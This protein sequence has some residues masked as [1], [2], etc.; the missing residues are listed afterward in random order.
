M[1]KKKI[2]VWS[3]FNV[4][5]GFSNVS[6]ALMEEMH[7]YYDVSVL[8]INYFGDTKY[9]TSK[10]FV[11]SVGREDILG[12]KRMNKVIEAVEPDIIFLFQDIFHISGIIKDL[13]EKVLAGKNTKIVVYFPIDGGPFSVAWHP[14]FKY[15][16]AVI[17]YSDY[18]IQVIK[19]TFPDVEKP[20]HK[21]YHGVNTDI[22]KRLPD[23]KIAELRRDVGKSRIEFGNVPEEHKEALARNL[24]WENKFVISNVNRFQQRKV[25]PLT[26]RAFSIFAKG[27]KECKCGNIMPANR[28]SCD[29]NMCPPE[30]IV[31]TISNPKKDAFLYLHMMPQEPG[32]GTGL[33][34]TLQNHLVNAGFSNH[35]VPNEKHGGIIGL[36]DKNIYR[37]DV[38]PEDVNE[39]YNASN[40]NISSTLGEGCG[41]SLIEAASAGTPSIAPKNSAI[42]EML[43]DTG[44]LVM[45]EG[46]AGMPYDCGF[47]RPLVSVTEMVKALEIEYAR[48]KELGTG[49]KEV[50]E[51]CIENIQGNF[52]WDDKRAALKEIFDNVL[53]K[54]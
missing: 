42:P 3:D 1:S 38:S 41:L 39:I 30:D 5:T 47:L 18:A 12:L 6:M 10:Y 17:T 16:D 31:K 35:D 43:K 37:G 48:W 34:D 9:D 23:K 8:G 53:T 40:I 20:I 25:I 22:F 54:T 50:R 33:A 44:H 32:M 14:T 13:K 46:I 15:A 4:P 51:E 26:L 29:L 21:L 27:Y 24:S 7:K 2:L 36:N 49:G 45:N 52:L 11:Y 28:A 19:D